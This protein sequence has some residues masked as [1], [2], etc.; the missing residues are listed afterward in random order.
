[1]GGFM[2]IACDNQVSKQYIDAFES[3]GFKVVTYAGNRAD[4]DWVL[5]AIEKGAEVIISPDLDIPNMIQDI[6]DMYWI[7]YQSHRADRFQYTLKQLKLIE[8]K[9]RR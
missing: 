8:K 9:L 6:E 5:E 7:D 2:L 4:E 3:H 1:M